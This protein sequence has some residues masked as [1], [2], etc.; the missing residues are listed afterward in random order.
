[1]ILSSPTHRLRIQLAAAATLP[2][3]C[4]VSY[5]D[6]DQS[7][8]N[9]VGSLVTGTVR[10]KSSS[11]ATI[12]LLPA[13]GAGVERV[14]KFINISNPN[15]TPVTVSIFDSEGAN[16]SVLL[17]PREIEGLGVLTWNPTAGWGP[18]R[19]I[20]GD[21]GVSV[22]NTTISDTGHFIVSF[23]NGQVVNAGLAVGSDGISITTATVDDQGQLKL[24]KSDGSLI[25]AGQVQG[26]KGDKGDPGG[27][28]NKRGDFDPDA[29]YAGGD[30]VIFGTR[31][32]Y[33]SVDYVGNITG[34]APPN[35]PWLIDPVAAR[36]DEAEQKL[37]PL[38]E[39]VQT[40]G[41]PGK[42]I[43]FTAMQNG[44]KVVIGSHDVDK[45]AWQLPALESEDIA[46]LLAAIEDLRANELRL[47]TSRIVLGGKDSIGADIEVLDA[48]GRYV[49][50]RYSHGA[51]TF[52]QFLD[53]NFREAAYMHDAARHIFGVAPSMRDYERLMAMVDQGLSS[54][55]RNLHCLRN[56]KAAMGTKAK[57]RPVGQ[58]KLNGI[59]DSNQKYAHWLTT[60]GFRLREHLGDAGPGFVGQSVPGEWNRASAIIDPISEMG[61]VLLTAPSGNWARVDALVPSLTTGYMQCSVSDD[62]L[63]YYFA[64]GIVTGMTL[65]YLITPGAALRYRWRA[66]G[67]NST[68]Y[69]LDL[70]V[71]TPGHVGRAALN[72]PPATANVLRLD[73]ERT[74]GTV[75]PA[76]LNPVTGA[77]GIVVNNF[78][79]S[80]S[81]AQGWASVDRAQFIENLRPFSGGATY[82]LALGTNDTT[83]AEVFKANIEEICDRI[84]A[85]CPYGDV[86]PDIALIVSPEHFYEAKPHTVKM[87]G[88]RRV[89]REIA[90]ERGY[91]LFD[92][93]M[94]LGDPGIDYGSTAVAA[95]RNVM[96]DEIHYNYHDWGPMLGEFV[97][98]GLIYY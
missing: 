48:T 22:T 51:N 6:V 18:Q 24:L 56:L 8:N 81:S 47:G 1:M 61:E 14:V 4:I 3:N 76:G 89:L 31:E 21:A 78:A 95:A 19:N 44:R 88:Y 50:R 36:V 38:T 41:V 11:T 66:D 54:P 70:S 53:T 62:P 29:T 40:S 85:S 12:D 20:K 69:N 23:S 30:S 71:G 46:A 77:N 25:I 57:G 74:A 91:A 32:Y 92:F 59:G 13:P 73:I 97:S 43:V 83:S 98:R 37:T 52:T 34:I 33:L 79:R 80:G 42:T 26:N 58:P 45:D 55:Y 96:P 87:Q 27:A 17:P 63:S 93:Q 7:A 28:L 10:P 64:D 75:K 84:K 15:A 16:T 90:D 86:P 60:V 2:V 68:W 65:D 72:A 67:V 5:N 35:A 9:G 82:L 39:A 49:V 94:A